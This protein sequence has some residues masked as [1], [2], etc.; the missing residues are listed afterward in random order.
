MYGTDPTHGGSDT[1][2]G[3]EDDD[4]VMGGPGNDTLY[5]GSGNDIAIGDTGY[6]V[7]T[8]ASVAESVTTTDADKGG[9]DT[10][11]AASGANVILGG[12]GNDTITAGAGND[13]ILGDNGLVG[14]GASGLG[15]EK[16]NVATSDYAYGGVDT[17]DAGDGNNIVLAGSG[18]DASVTAGI[19]WDLILGDNGRVVRNASYVPLLIESLTGDTNGGNDQLID[20]G[21]GHDTLIGG[22]GN[23]TIRGSAGND[24]VIGDNGRVVPGEATSIDVDSGGADT[25]DG[26]S[27]R[28]L[29]IGGMGGETSVKGGSEGDYILGDN[30]TILSTGTT[31]GDPG[32][33]T[34]ISSGSP[35][36]SG[37]DVLIDGEDGDDVIIG[38]SSGDVTLKGSAGN[39][40]ILGDN[41]TVY[42]DE[43]TGAVLR[44]EST[45]TGSGGN[46]TLISG[47][48]GDDVVVGG[49]GDD[50]ISGGDGDNVIL[51]D[52]GVV[53]TGGDIV[54]TAPS[55]AGRDTI[56]SGSGEDIIIGGSEGEFSIVSGA[57]NDVILGDN[58]WVGR[59]SYTVT[60]M[61]SGVYSDGTTVVRTSALG[62]S[63]V[64]IVSGAG[65][66]VVIGGKGDES[67]WGGTG[68]DVLVGDN[69]TVG[70]GFAWQGVGAYYHITTTYDEDN[71]VD[72]IRGDAGDDIILGGS[73]GDALLSGGTEKDIIL[74]DNGTV[75]RDA[76]L[77]VL[78]IES[79]VSDLL[80]GD[81]VTIDGGYGDDIIIAGIGNDG[82]SGAG[83]VVTG[84]LGNDVILGDNGVVVRTDPN[85]DDDNDIY[86]TDPGH[87]G[88]DRIRGGEG[89]DIILG[90]S[91]ND[92][93]VDAPGSV[94]D[95]ISGDAGS[96]I[97]LGDNGYV[98][99]GPGDVV[100][101][102]TSLGI[103]GGVNFARYGGNDV[104]DGNDA[105]VRPDESRGADIII[106]GTGDDE[107]SGGWD[108]S[109]DV[110][111]G[112]N[113]MVVRTDP[114]AG[115][116][117]DNDIVTL[118]PTYGGEDEITG[119][120]GADIIA[121]GTGY[122]DAY[123]VGGDTIHGGTGNDYIFG[124]G[125][126]IIRNGRDVITR[127][128][129]RDVSY[130]GDDAIDVDGDNKGHD[131]I[132]GGT[133]HDTIHG[134]ITDDGNEIIFGDNGRVDYLSVRVVSQDF[135]LPNEIS[136]DADLTSTASAYGGADTIDG[137][138]GNDIVIGGPENDILNGYYGLD[139]VIGDHGAVE[140]N[141]YGKVSK[142]WTI[143]PE[144]GGDDVITGDTGHDILFGG[145]G[146]D[147]IT[148]DDGDEIIF[149]DNGVVVRFRESA[150]DNDVYST[151]PTWG[152]IDTL[153]GGYGNDIILGGSGG[154]DQSVD[155]TAAGSVTVDAD[156]YLTRAGGMAARGDIIY[157]DVAGAEQ[158]TDE[159]MFGD[160]GYIQR[161]L[162][163]V[164]LEVKT[165][166]YVAELDGEEYVDYPNLGGDDAID[167][168][169]G[170]RGAEI[171]MGGYGHDVI[172]GGLFDISTDII[173]GDNGIT[174][175]INGQFILAGTYSTDAGSGG[176]DEING[177]PGSDILL[178]G[179]GD[180]LII[181]HDGDDYIYG[182]GGSDVLWGGVAGASEDNFRIGDGET[183]SDKF[184]YAPGFFE[185]EQ[186]YPTGYVPPLI[187]PKVFYGL[188]WDGHVT[189]GA[190]MIRG[191]YGTDWLFGG[192]AADDLDGG[193]A[194][195]MLTGE[196]ETTS[197]LAAAA[198]TWC[199]GVPTTIRSGVIFRSSGATIRFPRRSRWGT[200]GLPERLTSTL[201]TWGT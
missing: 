108:E 180:D 183:V 81:D 133:G 175:R 164:I 45:Y 38:G 169:V 147:H 143:M 184:D 130:G 123:G 33:V 24:I 75:Y 103:V 60:G 28:D 70:R 155:A 8:A 128:E 80:G 117:D 112:D 85:A 182:D 110:L 177:G 12:V 51:G 65:D 96:D 88:E 100:E 74:G 39:D 13:V 156:G 56:T 94:G 109:S 126:T 154:T 138:F 111:L 188:S 113:G 27:G 104:I 199:E 121:G 167:F 131:V 82:W 16:Y 139:V 174:T 91:E 76:S 26:G 62:G 35:A 7:R 73:L 95:R 172:H 17:I 196:S 37:S 107:I 116:D 170:N 55:D 173:L 120:G 83:A 54:S 14:L 161:N 194:T 195:T 146:N 68:N 30:G 162:D 22:N 191:G 145:T 200:R 6:V 93:A 9:N 42:T 43:I 166:S 176:N 3:S 136:L 10:V 132:I 86:S 137:G 71:G 92:Y 52:H 15:D 58:G 159:V 18:G 118:Y 142:I 192:G 67:I 21:S 168:A 36:S 129:S 40:V 134:G 97:I 185:A 32:V 31:F 90:G 105:G 19:G 193:R 47:G 144:T 61:V 1:L 57:G 87:G 50:V 53:I 158:G 46:E 4:I 187:T 48:D 5:T 119:G 49:L 79:K 11:T 165:R 141:S 197:P 89:D 186:D 69:G 198:T 125:A 29:L 201:R 171:I 163:G 160:N 106:G 72:T 135:H 124:D 84:G 23:D 157:G 44:V 66:D 148:G 181:G 152:G 178:G 99:R 151:Y 41:G 179:P 98:T 149:G 25:I 64:T 2:D 153:F 122:A 115:A 101:R 59:V 20:G 150:R 127:V 189:D 140:H 78:R 190:D 34:S 102:I 114:A 77:T 63:D